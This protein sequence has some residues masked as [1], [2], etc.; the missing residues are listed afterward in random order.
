MK[1]ELWP[2]EK[3]E[4]ERK[5]KKKGALARRKTETAGNSKE[6]SKKGNKGCCRGCQDKA[7]RC[8]R[9][10][11]KGKTRRKGG[12][13]NKVRETKRSRK[14]KEQVMISERNCGSVS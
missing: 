12:E 7:R 2:K 3:E 8:R 5:E 10:R 6:V 11:E 1:R 9:M 14:R 13:T 4:K